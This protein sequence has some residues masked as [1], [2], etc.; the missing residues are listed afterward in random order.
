M[1]K[2]FI[3]SQEAKNQ[4]QEK[5]DT[6]AQQVDRITDGLGK[7]VDKNI[8]ETVIAIQ[9]NDFG[10]LSS[11]EGH[12][13]WG[14]PYPWVDVAS[15]KA[16]EHNNSNSEYWKKQKIVLKHLKETDN[17]P[18]KEDDDWYEDYAFVREEFIKAREEN[19]IAM[20]AFQALLDE[21]YTTHEPPTPHAK[22]ILDPATLLEARLQP[23]SGKKNGRA[24]WAIYE[25]NMAALNPAQKEILFEICRDEM[26]AFTEFLKNK[27]FAE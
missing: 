20:A 21:F 22:L 18:P 23:A 5:W 13:G 2:N 1:E 10:T 12:F 27:F 7:K 8:K 25:E 26:K 19:K 11:C 3:P 17:K 14:H 6:I 16:R 4:K 24:N 9:A 15:Q